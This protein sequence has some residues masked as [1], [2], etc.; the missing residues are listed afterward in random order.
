MYETNSTRTAL[1]QVSLVMSVIPLEEYRLP[2]QPIFSPQLSLT[3]SYLG[4]AAWLQ[5]RSFGFLIFASNIFDGISFS[6]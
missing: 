6:F 3:S 2:V 5:N 1:N 4:Q